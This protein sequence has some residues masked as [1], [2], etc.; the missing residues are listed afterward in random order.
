LERAAF[1]L[2]IREVSQMALA[3]QQPRVPA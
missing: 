3:E 2:D 1:R